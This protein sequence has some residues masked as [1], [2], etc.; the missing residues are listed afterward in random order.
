MAFPFF[1]N[2]KNDL[3]RSLRVAVPSPPKGQGVGEGEGNGYTLAI[4][5]ANSSIDGE[6]APLDWKQWNGRRVS[7]SLCTIMLLYLEWCFHIIPW[8]SNIQSYSHRRGTLST[9]PVALPIWSRHEV[10]CV[11][12]CCIFQLRFWHGHR[13]LF[14]CDKI[15]WSL[16]SGK[17]V[18]CDVHDYVTACTACGLLWGTKSFSTQRFSMF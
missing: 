8:V 16:V 15:S 7:P 10:H 12:G 18:Y 14:E 5:D 11:S 4:F 1:V 6:N 13:S 2:H 17:A 3:R 9:Q